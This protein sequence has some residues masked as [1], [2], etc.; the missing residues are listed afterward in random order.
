MD[1]AKERIPRQLRIGDT[2]FT[3]L[4]TIGGD[5]FKIH[6]KNID[7]LYRDSNDICQ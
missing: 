7:H 3:S 4:E 5:L 1:T 6:P 2:C